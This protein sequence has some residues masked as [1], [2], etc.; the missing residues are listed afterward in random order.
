MK[1]HFFLYFSI[2]LFFSFQSCTEKNPEPIL[3]S[4]SPEYSASHMP[5][6]TL[7]AIGEE[8]V[9][10]AKIIF[11]EIEKDTT[12]VSSTELT[13]QINPEDTFFPEEYDTAMKGDYSHLLIELL[14]EVLNPTPGGGR[15]ARIPYPIYFNPLFLEPVSISEG[16]QHHAFRPD[17]AID[18]A[19][20]PNVVYQYGTSG[21]IYF[22]GS[23]D[24]GITWGNTVA[25]SDPHVGWYPRIATDMNG[26]LG[27]V[28][29]QDHPVVGSIAK[30]E[31]VFSRS[32]N[33][34][35]SWTTP[36]NISNTPES[37]RFGN[38]SISNEGQINIVWEEEISDD[39]HFARSTDNGSNWS[40]PHNISNTPGGNGLL[41]A[42][43][44]ATDPDGNI[45]VCW[46]DSTPG[47][48]ALYFSRS[49][50]GGSNWTASIRIP[51]IPN[52]CYMPA[53]AVDQNNNLALVWSQ[54]FG[55]SIS[56][57]FFSRSTNNG[58]TWGTPVNISNS[59]SDSR[60][61][62]MAIDNAGNINVVWDDDL[63]GS[64]DIYF[65]RSVDNG[66]TWFPKTNLSGN[67][68]IS[69]WPIVAVDSNGS[70][71][72]VWSDNS[73]GAYQIFF[74]KGW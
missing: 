66:V 54:Y 13:C 20:N 4:V 23:S 27:V 8:F 34:G 29:N 49:T 59:M 12:F 50:D 26:N 53:L 41:I 25:I 71:F 73:N 72:V 56:D 37:S 24:S 6:F 30:D 45:N 33:S 65:T 47:S 40:L 19:D 61:A 43:T 64:R 63:P 1:K 55:N 35:S 18:P 46:H 7:I 31:I 48:K 11:N 21:T 39:I 2:L 67:S 16:T 15:S 42:S 44:I 28:W 57:V 17:I 52:S 58:S 38:I 9:E 32:T 51:N 22:I 62:N 68:G 5:T 14:V 10:G 60:L 3:H 70:I 36:I 74:S 69:C